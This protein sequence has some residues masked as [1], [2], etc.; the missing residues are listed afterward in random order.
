MKSRLVF[1]GTVESISNELPAIRT[2]GRM[3]P[4][5]LQ[6]AVRISD[7]LKTGPEI[8]WK[9]L[10]QEVQLRRS[11]SINLA[12]VSGELGIEHGHQM[13]GGVIL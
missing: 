7:N 1:T 6:G 2:N 10:I 4:E 5:I 3:R 8:R 13:F 12:G 9:A 11:E